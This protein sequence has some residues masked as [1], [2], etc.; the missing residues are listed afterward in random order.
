MSTSSPVRKVHDIPIVE[1]RRDPLQLPEVS[2]ER[3]VIVFP[4]TVPVKEP[5]RILR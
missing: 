2:P 3:R 1:P 4:S 5:V